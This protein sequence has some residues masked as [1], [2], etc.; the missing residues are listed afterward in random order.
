[1][2]ATDEHFRRYVLVCEAILFLLLAVP[3]VGSPAQIT[4][5]P[6][7]FP[8]A[9]AGTSY[10]QTI[11]AS[12][13][14]GPYSYAITAGALP[15]GLTLTAATGVISGTPVGSGTANFTIRAQDSLGSK[16]T[17]AYN[18]PVQ[19]LL[20][21]TVS[22][23]V[24]S[25]IYDA[26]PVPTF[27]AG[28]FTLNTILTNNGPLISR[29]SKLYF[30]VSV[31]QK[32]Y[33]DFSK[34]NRLLTADNGGGIIGDIQT[35]NLQGQDLDTGKSKPISFTIGIGTHNTFMIS[36]DLYMLP[37]GSA[38]TALDRAVFKDATIDTPNLLGKFAL[39]VSETVDLRPSP[40]GD[41]P[42]AGPFSNFGVITGPGPLSRSAVA[43]DPVLPNRIAIAG[44]DYPARSVRISTSEDGGATW[45]TTTLDATVEDTPFFVAQNP[46]IAFDSFGRLSVVY[47][48]A[49]LEDAQNAIVISES[50]DLIHFSPPTSLSFH[51]DSD[52]IV[53]SR[54]AIAINSSL[55]RFVAW[56]SQSL[57]QSLYNIVLVR[58]SEGGLFGTPVTVTSDDRVGAPALAL[59]SSS[60][61][62]GWNEWGF[63]SLPPYDTGGR[64]MIAVASD[65]NSL[66]FGTPQEIAETGIGFGHKINAMPESGAGPNL[67][68]SV[69][70]NNDDAVY[71]VF[72]DQ[73]NGLDII[74]ARSSDRGNQWEFKTVN[75]DS[76]PA[77]QFSPA[78][79]L[80]AN[81]NVKISFYDTRFSTTYETAHVFLA[82]SS[83]NG[84]SFENQRVTNALVNDSR[85]NPLRDTTVN[86]GDRT[87]VAVVG[88]DVVVAWTDTRDG[89]EEI[90]AS[91][92][93]NPD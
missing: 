73:G 79:A 53:D 27:S 11:T 67:G 81:G 65:A 56:E 55:G 10:N 87:A 9:T 31:F 72:A 13:G 58:S 14:T 63:N 3:E 54:P 26:T 50:T 83:D 47:S 7:S 25:K 85:T 24:A 33:G 28:K 39:S 6:G 80:D 12:G 29:T 43:V 37:S 48:V 61:Y 1:M 15:T 52:Q 70:P 75:D 23:R 57:D 71:A 20:T 18:L 51:L 88:G 62:V 92:I 69:D 74:F 66:Q 59:G 93:S 44:N 78:M 19:T 91:R 38:M 40:T 5:S 21:S 49:N 30:K 86:L 35:V 17:Q 60:V 16:G 2:A 77:D 89:T 4:L 32:Y 36:L 68:L 34:P 42:V 8:I 76:S 45:H 46:N 82:R 41:V 22:L 90:F 84:T 64:L